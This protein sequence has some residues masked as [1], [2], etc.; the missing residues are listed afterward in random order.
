MRRFAAMLLIGAACS[1]EP[2]QVPPATT[3]A[4]ETVAPSPSI[5]PEPSIELPAGLPAFFA[6]DLDPADVPT[7]ELVPKGALVTGVWIAQTTEGDALIVAWA[8]AAGDP[9]RR[10]G[11]I[12][13]WRRFGDRPSWRAVFARASL[14]EEGVLGV[15]A[16]TGD[17][18][19]DGSEDAL[20]VQDTG[21]TG[22][23]GRYLVLDLVAA[24][25]VWERELCDAQVDPSTAP[26]GLVIEQAVYEEGDAHC[27]PTA[28]R[29]TVLAYENGD[30]TKL[31]V[32]VTPV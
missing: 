9:F 12:A 14:A 20:V 1:G 18:T 15:R 5:A 30:W 19:G 7:A 4:P 24:A 27:C 10:D 22:A 17:V 26:V 13:A 16:T 29:R 23:C 3:V 11:G 6:Q 32:E 28:F 2:M 25:A 21:G 31:S 8:D